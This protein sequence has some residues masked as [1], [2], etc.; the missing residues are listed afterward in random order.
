VLSIGRLLAGDDRERYYLEQVGQGRDDY[1][2]GEADSGGE[3]A[4][5]GAQS[6]GARG[7]VTP[8]GLSALL[9]GTDPV[10]GSELRKS[11]RQG[12]VSGFDLTFRPPK[13]VSL[14][15]GWPSRRSPAR[16]ASR[17]TPRLPRRWATSS[18]MLAAGAVARVAHGRSWGRAS[19]LRRFVTA[20]RVLGIRCCTPTLSSGT[21]RAATTASGVLWTAG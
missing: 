19:S 18:A 7:E 16:S 8:D 2:A 1:Y 15:W 6:L 17:T 12:G 14:L 4:G 21:S 9:R 20:R 11:T 5:T 13:S 3:W 10:G